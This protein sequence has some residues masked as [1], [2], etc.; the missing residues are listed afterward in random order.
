MHRENK[1]FSDLC[2]AVARGNSVAVSRFRRT[3]VPCLRTIIRRALRSERDLTRAPGRIRAAVE[4]LRDNRSADSF[5]P[6]RPSL[7]HVARKMCDLLIQELQFA[8]GM[9]PHETVLRALD[10][11]TVRSKN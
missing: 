6:D 3:V 4:K 5:Q 1:E 9:A 8:P 10:P 7:S 2:R 11:G